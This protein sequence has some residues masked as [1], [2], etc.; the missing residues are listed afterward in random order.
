MLLILRNINEKEPGTS[1]TSNIVNDDN[2]ECE[3]DREP[4]K[5]KDDEDNLTP[6]S[7]T[8]PNDIETGDNDASPNLT[9]STTPEG[10]TNDYSY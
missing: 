7:M 8:Q 10:E 1:N 6:H 5:D 4:N 3:T 9:E 2:V